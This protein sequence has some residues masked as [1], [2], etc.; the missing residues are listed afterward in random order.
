[1]LLHRR[2]TQAGLSL[3]EF[4]REYRDLT[5]EQ[6]RAIVQAI[7]HYMVRNDD[8]VISDAD[9][10]DTTRRTLRNFPSAREEDAQIILKSLI[11]RSGV[12]REQKP[13][14]IDFVH[15]T[16][17]EFLAAEIFVD[18]RDYSTLAH[19]I[20]DDSW[21]QVVL[22]ASATR[23]RQFAT[24]LVSRMIELANQNADFDLRRRHLLGAI[25]CRY[26][27]L[28]MDAEIVEEL[29]EIERELVPPRSMSDAEALA[30]SGDNV[31][32][33]LRY[34]RMNAKEA[35]ACVRTL[36]LVGTEAARRMLEGYVNDPR[37]AVASELAQ[38]VD[39]LRLAAVRS[40]IERGQEVPASVLRQIT[41][42]AALSGLTEVTCLSLQGVRI[43]ECDGLGGLTSLRS[44][45]LSRSHLQSLVGVCPLTE[46]EELDI[47][48]TP[49]EVLEP[50][51]S[52][53]KLV[54]LKLNGIRANDFGPVGYLPNL[55]FLNL[56]GTNFAD[57]GLLSLCSKL[58]HLSLS[59][60]RVSN[61]GAIEKLINLQSLS[62]LGLPVDVDLIKNLPKLKDLGFRMSAIMIKRNCHGS[63]IVLYITLYVFATAPYFTIQR[64]C[65]TSTCSRT[66][67]KELRYPLP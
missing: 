64:T 26:A 22:F 57:L 63:K 50:I 38:A 44:L 18:V 30:D 62:L 58:E 33:L 1:L 19:R 48:F 46:L 13:D 3:S 41:D 40:R 21:R 67:E 49:V 9:A 4:P 60:T 5:Y 29:S 43:T 52:L 10:L 56:S 15:N 24:R 16:I 25:S 35:A 66:A 6:K 23:E 12:L 14:T 11:E 61:L 39:P 65:R 37:L 51:K 2:E 31:V 17:K 47:S 42:L 32:P 36:R 7:A 20:L 59:S 53:S 55:K 34:Q 54:N 8:S 45:D 27:A 28:H